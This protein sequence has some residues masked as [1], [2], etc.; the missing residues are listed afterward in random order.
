MKY[1][2]NILLPVTPEKFRQNHTY[3]SID[4]PKRLLKIT[5]S[6]PTFKAHSMV[7]VV[8]CTV[9]AVYNI[10][11]LGYFRAILALGGHFLYTGRCGISVTL[12]LVYCTSNGTQFFVFKILHECFITLKFA[13]ALI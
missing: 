7:D 2:K 12:L 13:C 10:S 5:I 1:Q 11:A 4:Q 8:W 3:T 6:V 9:S